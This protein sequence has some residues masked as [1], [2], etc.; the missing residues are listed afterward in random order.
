MAA[1]REAGRRDLEAGDVSEVESKSE[2]EGEERTEEDIGMKILKAV[3]GA[4][5][6]PRI[7]IAAYDGG[8]NPEEL[9]DWI[10]SMD[11]NFNFAEIP[12]DKKVKFAVTRLKGH[13]FLWWDGVQV[14]RRRLYKQSI[15]N[16]SRMIAKLKEKFLPKDYQLALHR[17]MHNLRQRLLTIREYTEE[18]YKINIRA[19]YTED[20]FEKVS[21]Y[22][23]GL[24]FDI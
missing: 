7:E 11:K 16:W 24:K 19:G 13:A 17:Q 8:L 1:M 23:S 18:F 3:I 2:V 4:S 21:R 14:E 5:S 12:E 10:N 6:K 15:K 9:V 20:T 22:M